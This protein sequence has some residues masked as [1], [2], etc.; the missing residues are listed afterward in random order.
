MK[1]AMETLSLTYFSPMI[2]EMEHWAKMC[3]KRNPLSTL[4]TA[5]TVKPRGYS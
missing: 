1:T 4:L 5:S 3:L 2:M